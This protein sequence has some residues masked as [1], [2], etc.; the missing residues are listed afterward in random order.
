MPVPRGDD[1]GHPVEPPLPS[2][3]AEALDDAVLR[4]DEVRLVHRFGEHAP[5]LPGMR[6]RADQQIRGAAVTVPPGWRVRQLHPVPLRFGTGGVVDHRDRPARRRMARFARRAQRPGP[7]LGGEPRVGPVV[8]EAADLVEQRR[9]PQV[10]VLDQPQPAVLG[11]PVEHVRTGRSADAG[12]PVTGEVG[13]DG[14]AVVAGVP[15]DRRDR[16]APLA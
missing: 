1:G 9:R 12:L 2:Y 8:A 4:V 7:E 13:P 14:L 10:R 15:G 6:Q 16:P 3:T 5:P 11:E